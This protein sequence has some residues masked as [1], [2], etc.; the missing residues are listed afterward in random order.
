MNQD[1]IAS[2]YR[3][4]SAFGANRVGLVV[5][6]YDAIL[7]DLRRALEAIADG[8]I[9][10]RTE[11][12][13]HA[14]LIMAELEGVLDGDRAEEIAK[15]LRGFYSVTR[16]MVLEANARG[17]RERIEKLVTLYRPLRQAWQQV[18]SDVA[19][20]KVVLPERDG[21]GRTQT[22]SSYSGQQ[23]DGDRSAWNG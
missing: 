6:L 21:L 3:Q 2:Y 17:S 5:K 18:E 10:R 15:Q 11:A 14:L 20:G 8:H 4:A 23:S 16:A 13:N 22:I 19:T 7:E 9:E 1:Q 12:L